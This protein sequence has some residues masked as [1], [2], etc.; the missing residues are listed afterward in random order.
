M[1]INERIGN[2][3]TRE[4]QIKNR[5]PELGY[6]LIVTDTEATERCYFNGL[7]DSLPKGI[8]NKLVI[9]VVETKTRDMIDKCMDFIAYEAQYRMLWIVFDRDQVK[10]FDKII[11]VA[12]EKGI[13]VGWSN[14]CFEIWMYAYF[15]SMP[16]IH[17][18]WKCC[19]E[20]G[21][22]YERE[23]GQMYVKSDCDIYS[24]ICRYGDEEKAIRIAQQKLEQYIR[25]GKTKPSEMCPCTTVYELVRE[26]KS[27]VN[28][29]W[30]Q[31]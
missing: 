22:V 28:L 14:P 3:K 26:I 24:R 12:N 25:D 21:K 4:Q 27:K 15:G 1:A 5:V 20:F 8:K 31:V 11:K 16:T 7:Q 2:R 9:R 17:E 10:D 30:H 19:S 13:G 18:S 29:L 6:Y 23:T